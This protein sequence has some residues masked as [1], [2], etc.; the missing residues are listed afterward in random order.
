M[1]MYM[2]ICIYLYVY[3][4]ISYL[5]V[6]HNFYITLSYPPVYPI[7]SLLNLAPSKPA[8]HASWFPAAAG[9]GHLSG[10]AVRKTNENG[11]FV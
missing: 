5:S 4:Y 6:H 11:D 7:P 10:G 9:A 3:V 1:Y 2:Y 8:G